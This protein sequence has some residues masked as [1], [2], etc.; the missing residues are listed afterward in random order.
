[1]SRDGFHSSQDILEQFHGHTCTIAVAKV[2]GTYEIVDVKTNDTLYYGNPVVRGP[3]FGDF[4]FSMKSNI[5][6]FTQT[7]S[8]IQTVQLDSNDFV[9]LK[10]FYN[11]IIVK[12]PNLIFDSGDFTSL[13]E[14]ALFSILN[15]DD[16]KGIAQN[17][18]LPADL[19]E[20]IKRNHKALKITL[21]QCLPLIQY[22]SYSLEH[23]ISPNESITSLVL[24]ARIISNPEFPLNEPF[25][26]IFNNEHV[27][28]LS[29]W[30]N[31]KSTIYSLI[32]FNLCHGHAGTIVVA[33]VAGTDEIIG[34]Y[35]PLAWDNLKSGYMETNDCFRRINSC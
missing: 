16:L 26:T 15:R 3:F 32:F 23:S 34:G 27:A 7:M 14:S 13:K 30:I 18:T 19:K 33:K 9:D 28:E 25:S 17:P 22:F 20:W 2:A 4:E 5:S 6:D 1:M 35:N 10:K 24:P 21:Q 31:R 8:K 12:N 29:S 11:D